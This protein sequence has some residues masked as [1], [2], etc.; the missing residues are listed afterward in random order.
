MK[1]TTI[2]FPNILFASQ[3]KK[4][5]YARIL[6][7]IFFLII[8]RFTM[9][10]DNPFLIKF[11]WVFFTTLI[12]FFFHNITVL[13][14]FIGLFVLFPSTGW[15][16]GND[17]GYDYRY[18]FLLD[19]EIF[20][21]KP[22]EIFIMLFSYK[23][24]IQILY[25]VRS[26]S[27]PKSNINKS[28]VLF[29]S[30]VL[31]GLIVGVLKG[32]SFHNI[33]IASEFRIL[34]EGL[35]FFYLAWIC[36]DRERFLYQTIQVYI[37]IT[38]IKGA[39]AILEFYSFIPSIFF[40][41]GYTISNHSS[42]ISGIQD[43]NTLVLAIFFL[44]SF[45]IFSKTTKIYKIDT[46]IHLAITFFLFFV[47]IF[48]FR[49]TSYAMLLVGIFLISTRLNLKHFILLSFTFIALVSLSIT[50]FNK[51]ELN[52]IETLKLIKNRL[53]ITSKYDHYDQYDQ[54]LISNNAHIRDILMGINFVRDNLIVGLGVGSKFYADRSIVYETSL[55]HNGLLHSWIKFGILGALSYIFFYYFSLTSCIHIR[56]S[57]L[58]DHWIPLSSFSFIISNILSELF[59]PPFF[60]NFQK[61]S[62]LFLALVICERYWC[63]IKR[64]AIS[65]QVLKF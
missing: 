29:L 3:N 17:F 57:S 58:F 19:N 2:F 42:I 9:I 15:Y 5:F 4:G 8:T 40:T 61:T 33:F 64:Q 53:T 6:I 41:K 23:L 55:I 47:L 46:L 25:P 62:L 7:V 48:S 49:R 24:I 26:I 44:I 31:F 10:G 16:A 30:S 51:F 36:I 34:I 39:I 35:I 14:C 43:L 21:F 11:F 54:A 18:N 20:N 22:N 27:I 60:Q 56:W 12:V 28:S 65:K 38:I 45:L 32:H 50:F 37:F 63:F 52:E 59:M 1:A 13:W